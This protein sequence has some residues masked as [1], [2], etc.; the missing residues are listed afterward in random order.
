MCLNPQE[1]CIICIIFSIGKGGR[2]VL[3]CYLIRAATCTANQKTAH[4]AQ[5]HLA[6]IEPSQT[7][8]TRKPAA[9]APRTYFGP[10]LPQQSITQAFERGI[11][12]VR[13][14]IKREQMDNSAYER[15][16][17]QENIPILLMWVL[18]PR[19]DW[20]TTPYKAHAH[21]AGRTSRTR[22]SI[23]E[24]D[25]IIVYSYLIFMV[26]AIGHPSGTLKNG[27]SPDHVKYGPALTPTRINTL[28]RSDYSS[29]LG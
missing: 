9:A 21:S 11:L 26:S 15:C 14:G 20:S 8:C 25:T 7:P 28:L 23:G 17:L 5:K 12:M 6:A 1:F 10:K 2:V 16:P 22:T 29:S 18:Y 19:N 4:H 24:Q 27:F 13:E 3:G